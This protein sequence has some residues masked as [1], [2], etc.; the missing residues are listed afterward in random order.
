MK[1]RAI[2]Y[3]TG[4]ILLIL[5]GPFFVLNLNQSAKAQGIEITNITV[6]DITNVSAKINWE[7]NIDTQGKVEYW[8]DDQNH[9]T[10]EVTSPGTQ[11]SIELRS[12]TQNPY[13]FKIIARDQEGSEVES[14]IHS[15]E[16]ALTET[17]IVTTKVELVTNNSV[18]I[19][20]ESNVAEIHAGAYGPGISYG[21]SPGNYTDTLSAY[22]SS[23]ASDRTAISNLWQGT[24]YYYRASIG[25]QWPP[26]D[27]VTG[28]SEEKSF[29]TL[30]FEPEITS[31][32]P[33]SGPPGTEITI[34]GRGFGNN[35]G[36]LIAVTNSKYYDF[37][38]CPSSE[39]ISWSDTKIV[40]RTLS[41]PNYNPPGCNYKSG[42]IL[43]YNGSYSGNGPFTS[44][45]MRLVGPNFTITE[46]ESEVTPTPS[47]IPS[48][49]PP[50]QQ[51]TSKYGCTFSTE[52]QNENTVKMSQLFTEG[53]TTDIYLN[54]VFN[55]YKSIWNQNPRCDELQFHLDH[56]TSLDRLRT[57]LN[58]DL[59]KEAYGCTFST[60]TQN[61]STIKVNTLF[62]NGN[63]KK[64][65]LDGVYEEY[66]NR[67]SRKPRCEEFQFHL[68]HGT[69]L[70]RL[71][72][73]LDQ[74]AP[75]VT[76]LIPSAKPQIET[77]KVAENTINIEETKTFSYS[78]GETVTISGTT[79]PN[80]A[81]KITISSDPIE[82]V[83]YSDA[84]G[85]W[86]YNIPKS[87]GGGEHTIKVAYLDKDLKEV[88]TSDPIKFTVLPAKTK[89]SQEV[90]DWT[91]SNTLLLLGS[92]IAAII[93]I[94]LYVIKKP[95]ASSGQ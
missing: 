3:L 90:K 72:A 5:I 22:M 59:V 68:D 64:V 58:D 14:E 51:V 74:N 27:D 49:T 4:F 17:P 81:V 37:Q 45:V 80:T 2:F 18:V 52:T 62:N 73:W 41:G 28:Y 94:L 65:H 12:L 67:W 78:Q 30:D 13:S 44:Y 32:S 95:K 92:I 57:F 84:Q 88:N 71:I 40:A 1:K 77:V 89:T 42:N 10:T 36:G 21:T 82:A 50:G 54:N 8:V 46:E 23:P 79:S 75:S 91:T 19:S 39:I 56:G 43:V 35:V 69:P 76:S 87:L 31:V 34:K 11:H 16:R 63:E 93:L 15:F 70:D 7:T 66:Q 86:S 83:V 33:T 48:P 26:D 20:W 6:T 85:K 53:S 55:E 25:I 29:T 38:L 61:E 60:E 24:K 9:K 47:P